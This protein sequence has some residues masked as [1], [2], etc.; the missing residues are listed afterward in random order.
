MAVFCAVMSASMSETHLFA[1]SA[2]WKL[3]SLVHTFSNTKSK[4]LWFNFAHSI[5]IKDRDM[6]SQKVVELSVS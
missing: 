2:F 5:S 4:N 1:F 3:S 6:G